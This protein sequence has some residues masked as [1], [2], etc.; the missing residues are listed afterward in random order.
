MRPA[1][2][3]ALLAL[4][5][6]KRQADESY[7]SVV[8]RYVAIAVAI[9]AES[10]GAPQLA[11]YLLTVARHE[12]AFWY[13]VHSGELGGDCDHDRRG[14]I[15]PGSCR[16]WCLMQIRTGRRKSGRARFTGYTRAQLVGLDRG[17]TARCVETG[18]AYLRAALERCGD[19]PRCVFSVYG[20]V[21]P[22]ADALTRK[23]IR[24]RVRDYWRVRG[25][26]GVEVPQP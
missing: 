9:D 25:M 17:S 14:R 1:I 5:A 24:Q 7:T 21:G 6:P 20:G 10:N 3:L 13:S 11:A 15:I 19:R 2:F 12:S 23:R 22:G 16:S 4:M 8:L 18:A 26:L